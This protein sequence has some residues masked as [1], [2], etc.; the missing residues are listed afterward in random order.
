MR[1]CRWPLRRKIA[2]CLRGRVDLR[3]GAHLVIAAAHLC[4]A[5]APGQPKVEQTKGGG[6]TRPQH[7]WGDR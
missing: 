6:N 5:R 7:G 1:S 4:W 2:P 3:R